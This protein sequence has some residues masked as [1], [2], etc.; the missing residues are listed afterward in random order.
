MSKTD[1]F[2]VLTQSKIRSGLGEASDIP[3]YY[4]VTSNHLYSHLRKK[5]KKERKERKRKEKEE[6][7][8]KEKQEKEKQEKEKAKAAAY[9]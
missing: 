4:K 9:V 3:T 8:E 6:K 1:S 5:E 7:E 2:S